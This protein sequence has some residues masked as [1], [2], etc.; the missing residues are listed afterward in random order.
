LWAVGIG[1]AELVADIIVARIFVYTIF[2][3][4]ASLSARVFAD[5]FLLA[6]L[7]RTIG[8]ILALLLAGALVTR[9]LS[10]TFFI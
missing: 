8:I 6:A 1:S 7:P 2:F 10:H 5:S 3:T 9:L 4:S